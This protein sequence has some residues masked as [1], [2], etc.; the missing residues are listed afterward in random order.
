MNYL[1]FTILASMYI[2]FTLELRSQTIEVKDSY[3]K[4]GI[5]N[6]NIQWQ[7]AINKNKGG[8][9]TNSKGIA[10]LASTEGIVTIT[11]SC[12]GYKTYVDTLNFSSTATIYLDE[13]IFNLEQV[14]VTGTRTPRS[15]KETPVLT[16][17]IS[18]KDISSIKATT[19]NDILE[20]EMPS[21]EMNQHGYGAA[22][23]S[24][25]LDAKYTLVLIDGE[26][27]A[28]ETDGNVDFSRINA[29]NIER[30]E[31]VKGASSALYG[32]N[33]IGSVINIITRKP[34]KK[35]DILANIRYAEPNEK[36]VTKTQIDMYD[37][38]HI[39]TFFRNQDRQNMNADFSVGLKSNSIYS[40][41][42]IGYKSSD[43][44]QLF[45]TKET[46]KFYPTLD[47]I[48]NEGINK[49]PTNIIGFANY[50]IS[51][52]TGFIGKNWMGELRGN[53]YNH[54][55][56]DFDRNNKH[57][58]YSNYTAGGFIER[59]MK[60][61]N[62]IKLSL[63]HDVY[64]K[65]MFLEEQETKQKN[66]G[67]TFNQMRLI[68]S[69]NRFASHKLLVGTEFFHEM[70]ESDRFETNQMA[71]HSANDAVIFIQDEY[72]IGSSTTI[73]GGLRSRN[74][75]THNLH[76][77]PSLTVK[78]SKGDFNYRVSYA[79]GFRSPTL[80]ELYMKWS[81][82]EMFTIF[83]DKNLK[84]ETS[85]Y[86]A[87]STEY[88]NTNKRINLTGSAAYNHIYNKI[89]GIWTANQTEYHYK[90]MDEYRVI[91]AE[92]L[93]RWKIFKP[94]QLKSGYAY[95]HILENENITLL[96]TT[97]PHSL[98]AQLEYNLTKGWYE[99][100]TNIALKYVGPKEVSE[101]DE[102]NNNFY[103]ISYS[104]Y[105]L[106]NININQQFSRNYSISVGAKNLLN[107]TSPI[108]SFN[109]TSTV[110]RRFYVSIGYN[111]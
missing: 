76:F 71:T 68:Y 61:S 107:Y 45:D 3:T 74:H 86:F 34:S 37:E 1:K 26:R 38:P 22:L 54:E 110:G 88:L 79:R 58:L 93:L 8:A 109:T 7:N 27:M 21:V 111:F 70:L 95:T 105:T 102:I 18:R 51:S 69:D 43:A 67:N 15:L 25:G 78:I 30:V 10:S 83:G 11:A 104:S 90:N 60:H 55:E 23:S 14:T 2:A 101:F 41:N 99:L 96:S 39:K 100:N 77:S 5:A 80:K 42:Y 12:I 49:S 84:A 6:V 19:I 29:A 4:Q 64:T 66:Y 94:L 28:G 65:F 82:Q 106:L 16:Q 72:S 103:Q 75:S 98:T 31:I 97:S 35:F 89:G 85:N 13:D 17:L 33:A 24:Q 63:N 9:T 59:T 87:V 62:A 46:V 91:N 40:Q 48:A 50:T 73:V 32:S 47:S 108:L 92:I 52:R 81:H 20:M 57:N 56:F 53:Y 44:Y 36:N